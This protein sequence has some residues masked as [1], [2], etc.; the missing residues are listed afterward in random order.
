MIVKQIKYYNEDDKQ[1]LNN[2]PDITAEKLISGSYFYTITCKEIRI[3]AYPGTILTING[4]QVVIGE[5]GVYDILYRENVDIVSLRMDKASAEFIRDTDTAYFIITF[6]Q[7]DDTV[8][9]NEND[10]SSSDQDSGGNQDGDS[11]GTDDN[12]PSTDDEV[13]IFNHDRGYELKN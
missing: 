4:E 7:D 12:I 3:K 11:S 8:S 6:I 1:F 13:V 5:V 9:K 2:P 10:S